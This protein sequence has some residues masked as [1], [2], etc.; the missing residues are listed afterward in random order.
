MPAWSVQ[1]VDDAAVF[2]P[3]LSPVDQAWRDHQQLRGGPYAECVGPLLLA[4]SHVADLSRVVAAEVNA[5][6]DVTKGSPVPVRV[7]CRAGTPMVH[8]GTAVRTLATM[9]GVQAAGLEISYDSGWTAALQHALPLAVEVSRVAAER[10]C[11]LDEIAQARADD[12]PMIAKLRTQATESM[13]VTTAAEL[14]GFVIACRQRDLPF[15]LT[16]GLH[17]AVASAWDRGHAGEGGREA[18][19]ELEAEAEHGVVNVLL[20]THAA[21]SSASPA[22]IEQILVRADAWELAERLQTLTSKQQRDLRADFTS[23]GCCG[24]LDPLTELAA[25]SLLP[26]P[27]PEEELV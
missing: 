27:K 19:Y 14:A 20:A 3:G 5:N 18:E 16:G 17:H 22:E 4:P 23:Y 13:P 9:P 12:H 25:L 21:R 2:P 8:L 10:D 15:K 1:L 26:T 24:V 7:I 11:A 6:T